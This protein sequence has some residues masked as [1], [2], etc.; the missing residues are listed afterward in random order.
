MKNQIK[1]SL[2]LAIAFTFNYSFSQAADTD[3][4]PAIVFV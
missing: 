4:K 1:F 2:V 3:K